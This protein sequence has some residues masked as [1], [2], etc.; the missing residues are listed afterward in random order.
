[1]KESFEKKG[2]K[3]LAKIEGELSDI[4][5]S[6]GSWRGWFFRGVMQGA[7]IVIGTILAVILTGWVLSLLGVIPGLGDLAEYLRAVT[8]EVS[9]F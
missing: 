4:K 8:D 1:M 5:E 2:L 3:H 6:A 7:G 9:R